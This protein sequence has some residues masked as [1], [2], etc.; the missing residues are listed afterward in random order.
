M[1]IRETIRNIEPYTATTGDYSIWLNKN[2]S[3]FDMPS[4][5]KRELADRLLETDLNRYPEISGSSLRESLAHHLGV[6]KSYLVVGNGSDELIPY[7]FNLFQGDHIVLTPPTFSMYDFYAKMSDTAVRNVPLDSNYHIDVESIK[8]HCQNAKAIVICSPNNPTGNLQPREL[9]VEL[10]ETGKPVII[11]EAY[12]E[13]APE[14][15]LDLVESYGNLLLL[16]TF[17]KAFCMAGMRVGYSI[18]DPEVMKYLRRVKSPYNL[19]KVSMIA[20]QIILEHVEDILSRIDFITQERNRIRDRFESY[21]FP[22]QA[23]FILFDLDASDFLSRK[24]IA[25]RT[26]TGRLSD[27]FRVTVGDR[28][29]NQAFI[30]AL[31]EFL[32]KGNG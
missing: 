23:N 26:F 32:E 30:S 7:L 19:N 31:E 2:E 20:A 25:V 28:E 5:V 17:S 6:D 24:G 8:N 11:D 3:P 1:R 15:N 12:Q 10:L 4:Q 16:R 14:D 13:F 21:C 29:E 18:G 9:I 22:S 27:K